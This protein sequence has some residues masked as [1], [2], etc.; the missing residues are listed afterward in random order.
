MMTMSTSARAAVSVAMLLMLTVAG[1]AQADLTCRAE[2]DRRSVHR[3]GQVILTLT[4]EG[5]I[6]RQ[7]AHEAPVID[8]VDVVP[9]GTSQSYSIING[10]SSMAITAT[11]YLQV[12]RD[13]GFRIPPV[14]FRH[15]D[16]SCATEPLDITVVA[17]PPPAVSGNRQP[18]P[19]GTGD[20]PSEAGPRAGR[21]GDTAFITVDVDRAEAWVGQQLEMIFRYYRRSNVWD[22]PSYSAPRTE[23]FWRVDLPPERNYRRTVSGLVYDVTEIRYALFPTRAGDLVVEPA[24]LE[25]AG[26]PFDR[27]FGRGGRRRVLQTESV[28]VRVRDLPLPRPTGFSGIVAGRLEL[29]AAVD[30]DTVPRGE[31]LAL[32][33]QVAADAFLKSFTGVDLPAVDGLQIHDAGEALRE[34]VSGRRYGATFRQEKA[35][36]PLRDGEVRMPPVSLVWFDATDGEYRTAEA[37]LSNLIVTPSDRPVAGDDRSGFRRTEIARLGRDLAFIHPATGGLRR[38]AAPLL[39][40]WWWWLA[41]GAPWLLLALYR[42]RLGRMAAD[43]RDPVGHRRRTAL[44]RARRGL[45]AARRNGDAAA[46]SRAVT[47]FV[48]DHLGRPAA[49]LTAADIEG[50][51]GGCEAARRLAAVVSACDHARFGAGSA[52]IERLAD[53]A[54]ALMADLDRRPRGGHTGGPAAVLLLGL[55]LASGAAPAPAQTVAGPNPGGDPARLLAEANQ[56]YTGENYDLAV[57]RYREALNLGADDAVLHFNLG[58]AHARRGELGLAIASYLRAQRLSPRDRDIRGNL[59]WVR[60]HTRDLELSGGGL[61]PVVAQL[62]R[63]AHLLSLDEWAGAVLVL[64][65][66][67]AAMVAW[68]W[69]RGWMTVAQRR[70]TIAVAALLLL[71]GVVAATRWYE[72]RVR[73]TAVVVMEEVEVRSGPATS[74]PAVFRVHDGLL[75]TVSDRREGWVQVGLGGDWVGWMPDG[76]LVPVRSAARDQGR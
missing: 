19:S 23:G 47:G 70:S 49:G 53:E 17:A 16:R 69:R 61:P 20:E 6:G 11:Y 22:R 75:V 3:G 50:F 2:V 64:A 5:D 60:S 55:L 51:G 42:W 67:L 66:T 28:T 39:G 35:V 57:D 9:G 34:D 68:S 21:A 7:P 1:V 72:E 26:D 25:M 59:D 10:E 52:D 31:P 32:T 48:A 33:V 13:D 45:A 18:P 40:Q 36:V 30:R 29:T 73:D 54:D 46:L 12:R 74:F 38:Q 15:G 63:A 41:A 43:R 56:A 37:S 71:A 14:T 24:R 62:D 4:A 76:A 8:G 58:N 65:W 27:F 44:S